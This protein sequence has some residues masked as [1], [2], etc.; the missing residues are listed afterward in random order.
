[1]QAIPGTL[2]VKTVKTTIKDAAYD[3]TTF[4][5]VWRLVIQCYGIYNPTVRS[6]AK[7][8]ALHKAWFALAGPYR[9]RRMVRILPLLP[10]PQKS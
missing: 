10:P 8:T 2:F 7:T 4:Y 9:G 1:M 3:Q 6:A 5:E